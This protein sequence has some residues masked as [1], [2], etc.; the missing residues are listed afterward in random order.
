MG[1]PSAT[2]RRDILGRCAIFAGLGERVLEGL[3]NESTD[4]M[5][6]ELVSALRDT[7]QGSKGRYRET[8]RD[9]FS[10]L[11]QE[12]VFSATRR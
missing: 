9:E 10:R 3:E 6:R 11:G 5:V 4:A 7:E 12:R 1:L 2:E 8:L